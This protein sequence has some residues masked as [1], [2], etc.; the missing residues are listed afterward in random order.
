[1]SL[2]MKNLLHFFMSAVCH[3]MR[4]RLLEC[5]QHKQPFDFS[6]FELKKL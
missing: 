1:M 2:K 5:H 6:E 4:G 3:V